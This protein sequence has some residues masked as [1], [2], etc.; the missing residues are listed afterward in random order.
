MC[1]AG[2]SQSSRRAAGGVEMY[3]LVLLIAISLTSA[4][5]IEA[6]TREINQLPLYEAIKE[7]AVLTV[8]AMIISL[9]VLLWYVLKSN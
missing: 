5:L 2:S 3:Y 9:A 4:I 6:F 8:A 7:L 1:V